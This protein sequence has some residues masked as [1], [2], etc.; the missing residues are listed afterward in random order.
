MRQ[1]QTDT[2]PWRTHLAQLD[3]DLDTEP[4]CTREFYEVRA[5]RVEPSELV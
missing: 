3:R 4:A 1:H 5:K 2:A